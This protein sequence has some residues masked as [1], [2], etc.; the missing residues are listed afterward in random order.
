MEPARA[1]TLQRLASFEIGRSTEH[2]QSGVGGGRQRSMKG[3]GGMRPRC[4]KC[5]RARK[6]E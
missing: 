2:S 5:A 6:K 3:H 4:G 1:L